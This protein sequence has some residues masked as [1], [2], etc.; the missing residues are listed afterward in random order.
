MLR[1]YARLIVFSTGLLVGVQLPGFVD[2][3]TKRVDAH[4]V[5]AQRAF[6]GFRAT[7]DRYYNG[8]I[9]ALLNHHAKS[10][11]GVF[12]DEAKTIESLQTRLDSLASEAAAMRAPLLRR[13][14]HIAFDA[15]REILNE[16]AKVFSYTVPLSPAAIICGVSI[17]LL[18]A[19]V[20]ESALLGVVGLI[21]AAIHRSRRRYRPVPVK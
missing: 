8:S 13:I 19:L 11:D 5:E 14:I 12:I 1:D 16:T 6:G 15:D 2:Q 20:I 21:A 7:A 18:I 4:Y 9:Q 3:Y 10:G 17:G